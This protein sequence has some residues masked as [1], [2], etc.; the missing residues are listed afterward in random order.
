MYKFCYCINFVT[1]KECLYKECHG[2]T[3]TPLRLLSAATHTEPDTDVFSLLS[4]H[5]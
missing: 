3:P 1:Y 4:I 2:T 5:I